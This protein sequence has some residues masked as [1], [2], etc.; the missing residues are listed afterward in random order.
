MGRKSALTPEQW[1]E[2]ER[3]HLVDGESINSLAKV[4]GVNEATIRKKINPNKSEREKSA[5]PLRELA[6]EKVEADRRAKDISEQIAAL[7][8]ARQTIVND[9][10]QKLTNISGHLASAA[11][12]GAAT[13]HRLAA[14][15]NEQA[16]KVDD[17]NPLAA[18]SVAALKGI[19][20]LNNLANNASEIGLNLLR[21]NKAEI[22]KIVGGKGDGPVVVAATSLD[23]RL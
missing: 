13:A 16:A 22:E 6:Q 20:A 17:A 5:K 4:F 15:A 19:A 18:D 12:Y 7:P 10:A 11:E 1:A 23:E 8:I 21:A 9:L 14:I 3:R 2:V